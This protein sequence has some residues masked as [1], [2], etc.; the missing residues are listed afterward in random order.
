MIKL[1]A[2]M[3]S[4]G[5]IGINNTIP[6]HYSEDFKRFKSLTLNHILIMGQNTVLSL[7]NKLK[8]RTIIGIGKLIM[9]FADIICESFEESL[10]KAKSIQNDNQEIWIS[11]GGSVY[12][13]ALNGSHVDY[14]DLTIVEEYI[15]KNTDKNPVYFPIDQL[16]NFALIREI[17]NQNAKIKHLIY[18]KM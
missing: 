5:L 10:Q 8:K 1:I 18:K 13:Q 14:I 6:W 11:G 2:A 4:N 9:P 3:D 17:K 15:I 12:S 16:F 7:P